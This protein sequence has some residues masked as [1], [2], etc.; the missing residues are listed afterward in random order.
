MSRGAGGVVVS[1]QILWHAANR[2][3]RVLRRSTTT[4][5]LNQ[6]C[7]GMIIS[8]SS[9]VC[10]CTAKLPAAKSCLCFCSLAIKSGLLQR[11]GSIEGMHL[12]RCKVDFVAAKRP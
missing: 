11:A 5:S 8:R 7:N 1:A 2:P 6:S 4:K 3:A 12:F 9:C 10:S